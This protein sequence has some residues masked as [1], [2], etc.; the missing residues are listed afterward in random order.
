MKNILIESQN[1]KKNW[2]TAIK[3]LEDI[4]LNEM[5]VPKTNPPKKILLRL[6]GNEVRYDHHSST[7]GLDFFYN[8]TSMGIPV[9]HYGGADLMDG[10]YYLKDD[11]YQYAFQSD[12]FYRVWFRNARDSS[13]FRITFDENMNPSI[14]DKTGFTGDTTNMIFEG[15]LNGTIDQVSWEGDTLFF[16]YIS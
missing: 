15:G 12:G 1:E 6:N 4:Y 2:P 8:T 5:V 7:Y 14:Y 10:Y 13:G 9:I 3:V 11:Y 16:D